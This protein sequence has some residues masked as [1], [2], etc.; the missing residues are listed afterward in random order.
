MELEKRVNGV[1]PDKVIPR[2]LNTSAGI[3]RGGYYPVV[4]DPER[5]RISS[6]QAERNRDRLF[7][8][9]Y[10]RA[11]TSRGFTKERTEVERPIHLSLDVMNRHVAEVAHD[12][13]HREAIMQADRFL[14]EPRI[15]D[16]V[17]ETMGPHISGLFR[18]WLQHIANEWAYDRAG[19]GKLERIM[20]AARRNTTF[21][22][23][24]YR[25]GTML[26]QAAGYTNSVERVGMK[27]IAQGLSATLRNPLAANRFAVEHSHELKTRFGQQDRDMRE[28][29][30]RLAGKTDLASLVQRYGYSGIS[31]FDRLVAVPTWLGAYNKAIASGMEADQ[32]VHEAD[33]AVR[34][35]QGAGGA[36]DLAAIQRGRGPAGELGKTLTMFY[37]FQSAQYN[38]FVRLGW[39]VADAK[40]GKALLE[41]A[42]ELAARAMVLTLFV[43]VVGSLLGGRGP[44]EENEEAWTEWAA[45]ESLYGLAAPIPFVRDV[46]PIATKKATGD[47]SYGYRFTPVA[48]MGESIERVAGDVRKLS[49]GDETTRATRNM[50]E[51]LGYMNGLTPTPFSG[52]MAATAQFLVDWSSGEVEPASAGEVW[53]GVR[54][55]RITE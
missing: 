31:A 12:L 17:D 37:S 19:V 44:D 18:P 2:R 14:S 3:L 16:A 54:S 26:T 32:A 15:L 11:S 52:Q 20:R 50:I 1:A 38:R 9:N 45:K 33:A 25:I 27:W 24:A 6:E 42:P 53:E 36:K 49:E 46:V 55:G 29:Q 43:P 22:G 23:M 4:Y 48:G 35:S 13:T 8:N 39:D 7:E 21:V 30:R 47:R 51:M 40:R 41:N 28:N 10:Q 34:E 5:S